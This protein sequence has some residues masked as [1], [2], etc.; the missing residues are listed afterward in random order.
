M[1]V[2][3]KIKFLTLTPA[4]FFGWE[5]S[6][7]NAN[8]LTRAYCRPAPTGYECED[9]GSGQSGMMG[10]FGDVQGRPSPGTAGIN[11]GLGGTK[12]VRSPVNARPPRYPYPCPWG[13]RRYRGRCMLPMR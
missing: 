6:M 12:H 1:S 5:F 9:I 7:T 3:I 11:P 4:L 10:P 13:Y 2:P 8:A